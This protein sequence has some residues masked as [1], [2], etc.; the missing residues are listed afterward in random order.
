[1]RPF[2]AVHQLEVDQ[3]IGFFLFKVDELSV[4]GEL[5]HQRNYFCS[6]DSLDKEKHTH[7]TCRL[8]WLSDEDAAHII[9]PIIL[10]LLL[11]TYTLMQR[12][13]K[14]FMYICL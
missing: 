11:L 13:T 1:M 9:I 10:L 4:C 3:L 7:I 5:F 8:I 6:P 2:G 14:C 12:C